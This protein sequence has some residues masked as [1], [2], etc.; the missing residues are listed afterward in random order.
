MSDIASPAPVADTSHRV[1]P[2]VRLGYLV[3]I[4]TYPFFFVLF[5]GHLWP[6]HPSMWVWVLLGGH[7]WIWP[8]VA[9]RIAVTS[10]DSKNAE[11]RNLLIDALIIGFLV[12]ITGYSLW[13]NAAAFL[14][15]H[16]GNISVGGPRF[17]ARALLVY[18]LGA[19]ASGVFT[20]FHPDLLGASFFT[21]A[22]SFFVV[23]AHTSVFAWLTYQRQRS[24]V[25]N[26]RM[27]RQQHTEIE[28]KGRLLE[29]RTRELE[30]ALGAAESANA[31]KS[32]FLATMSH[33]LRTPLNSIIGFAN[34]L[35]RNTALNLRPQDVVYLTRI[36]ANGSHLLELINGVLDL[37]KIDARQMQ[38]DIAP[39]DV[40]ALLRETL[41]ELEPQAETREV[42]FVADLPNVGLLHTD[43][44]RLKQIVLNLVSNAV[45]F[46]HCGTVTVRIVPNVRTGLPARIE[47]TDTG[48]GIAPD[49][50]HAVFN[51]FQQ[52]DETTSRHYGGTGL[53]LTITRSLAHLMGWDIEVRSEVG[54][55]S[56][57]SVVIDRDEK[58]E[59]N[60]R[61]TD[62]RS[63]QV[64][65]IDDDVAVRFGQPT[66][67]QVVIQ[68]RPTALLHAQ[69]SPKSREVDRRPALGPDQVAQHGARDRTGRA[70]SRRP[71]CP[72][73]GTFRAGRAKQE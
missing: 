66:R 62:H 30:K 8:H 46:T 6:R 67:P 65:E 25:V 20:G 33:E 9:R 7:L 21:Q 36:S 71:N 13:P 41:G 18:L 3:R 56:T 59:V 10:R 48:V 22:V 49:R 11:L 63:S 29:L 35:L 51:A 54:V 5:A 26:T 2:T 42:E 23:A 47:V 40:A 1:H 24:G 60:E 50:L 12:P 4:S 14:G 45:K 19:V 34:I 61:L 32:N 16:S 68:R 64:L 69:M 28:E 72:V 17:A 57:F 53:G 43:R 31:A 58:V 52:E 15:I 70:K 39:V 27:I 73:V 38:L 44:S 55:G 37:S